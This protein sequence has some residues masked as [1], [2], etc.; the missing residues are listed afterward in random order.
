M[1]LELAHPE[2]AARPCA[3]CCEFWYQADGKVPMKPANSK[4][5]AHRL[6]RP[7][8]STPPCGS[9]PK[10]P[11]GDV[12]MPHRA[13]ELTEQNRQCWQ[14]FRECRAVNWQVPDAADPLVRR[15]A[16]LIET[17]ERAVERADAA[18]ALA[19]ALARVASRGGDG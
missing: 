18:S 1:W 5:P 3:E 14:H 7:P 8:G 13:A 6:K 11:P 16:D 19:A 10:I 17:A 4:D 12:P 9:C 15:H 2:V